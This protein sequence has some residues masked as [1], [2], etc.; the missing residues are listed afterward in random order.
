MTDK[1]GGP[2]ILSARPK[3]LEGFEKWL[4]SNGAEILR[5][6]NEY[7]VLRFRAGADIG[8][9][10]RKKDGRISFATTNMTKAWVAYKNQKPFPFRPKTTRRRSK[11]DHLVDTLLER[12]GENCVYCD[13]PLNDDIT[14]E[15]FLSIAHGGTN[16]ISNLGL[17]HDRCNRAV[18]HLS[19]A[20]K[21]RMRDAML[22]HE[23]QD[24]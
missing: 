20:E 6:T 15:H 2:S 14:L 21:L 8:V 7:E 18:S 24:R 3:Q 16:H 22:A 5:P 4:V 13:E 10:Y 11:T 23:E 9:A 17:A 19:I 1:T 12:D